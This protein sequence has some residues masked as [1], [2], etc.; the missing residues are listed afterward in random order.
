MTA[1]VFLHDGTDFS[2]ETL[3]HSSMGGTES[4]IVQLAEALARRGHDVSVF[5]GVKKPVQ[6]FSVS[7]QP[8]AEAPQRASGEIG[9]AV[10]SPR[11]FRDLSFA[12]NV[13]WL[14]NPTK[15]RREIRRGN[16]LP[17]LRARPALVVLGAY[18]AAHVP[19]WLPVRSRTVLHH[20]IHPDFFQKTPRADPPPPRAIFTS[21]PY[22]GLDRVLHL[23]KNVKGR[24]PDAVLEVFAPKAH[25]AEANAKLAEIEG[26]A[27]RG[28]IP[29]AGIAAEL[30]GT[31]VQLTPGHHDETYCLAAAEA[32]AAGVPIVTFG[33]GALA[34]RVRNRE[35][36]FIVRN[37][38]EFIDRTVMLLTQDAV[39]R[40][41]HEACL[42][43]AALTTWDARAE[44]WEQFFLNLR[45]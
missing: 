12:S 21:Q 4:S 6:E 37:N 39:W 15:I 26:V 45:R 38:A 8:I 30:A 27:F 3:R 2:G 1:I 29:R 31:R 42:S 25:Q 20:G 36:G 23:W 35:T 9:I 5:N 19:R 7:W 40:A 41:M 32:T 22:R 43:E 24:V 11:A 18:H 14:H 17:L 16:V 28:S 34:E 13:L 33:I 10:G 44:E